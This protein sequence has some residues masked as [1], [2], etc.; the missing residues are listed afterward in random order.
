MIEDSYESEKI[1]EPSEEG[2]KVSLHLMVLVHGFQGNSL[3]MKL[4]KNNISLL[5]PE[6]SFL[7]SSSNEEMTDTD[8][9]EMGNRLANEV[10]NH[11]NEFFPP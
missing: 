4:I 2:Q 3:D 7:C 10:R 1:S 9:L 5:Y 11:I 6:V 8:I